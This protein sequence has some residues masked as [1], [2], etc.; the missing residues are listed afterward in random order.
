[1]G[2]GSVSQRL[3]AQQAA[4]PQSPLDILQGALHI[5][6]LSG[7]DKK[8]DSGPGD[9]ISMSELRR[10]VRY[11]RWTFV[12]ALFRLGR[13]KVLFNKDQAERELDRELQFHLDQET[14]RYLEQGLN[15]EQA[16]DRSAQ[17][18]WRCREDE[19]R[20]PRLHARHLN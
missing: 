20:L 3:T 8:E 1:M 16:K 6:F 14:D 17:K 15:Y 19:G 7:V 18:F 13:A 10:F 5:I 9:A 12:P 4:E 11:T 2:L